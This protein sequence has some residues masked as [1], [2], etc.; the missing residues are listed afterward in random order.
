[1]SLGIQILPLAFDT[2]LF[3]ICSPQFW[4][5]FSPRIDSKSHYHFRAVQRSKQPSFGRRVDCGLRGSPLKQTGIPY[6]DMFR[7]PG[8]EACGLS[9]LHDYKANIFV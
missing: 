6:P 2:L 1:M 5:S 4:L 8:P 9:Y 3:R 7:Q